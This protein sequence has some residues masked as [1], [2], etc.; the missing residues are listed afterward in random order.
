MGQ[1]IQCNAETIQGV[2]ECAGGRNDG[3]K[4]FGNAPIAGLALGG[5]GEEKELLWRKLVKES[6]HKLEGTSG[7]LERADLLSKARVGN[8]QKG[9]P[10]TDYVSIRMDDARQNFSVK[11]LPNGDVLKLEDYQEDPGPAAT[12]KPGEV[13]KLS[14]EGLSVSA[15]SGAKIEVVKR[16]PDPNSDAFSDRGNVS[17]ISMGDFAGED[18]WYIKPPD[19]D[20]E[21]KASDPMWIIQAPV[22][23]LIYLDFWGGES[24]V[25]LVRSQWLQKWTRTKRIGCTYSGSEPNGIVYKRF[26]EAGE[27][28]IFGNN[29]KEGTQGTFVAFV[30]PAAA[31]TQLN[32][33]IPEANVRFWGAEAKYVMRLWSDD[34]PSMKPVVRYCEAHEVSETVLD[35][36]RAGADCI[37][38]SICRELV[39]VEFDK[40][41]VVEEHD[42]IQRLE[43]A[44]LAK[45]Q[46][47]TGLTWV[48]LGNYR[49]EPAPDPLQRQ[50]DRLQSG[51]ASKVNIIKEMK[52]Q[53]TPASEIERFSEAVG[54]GIDGAVF[55][56]REYYST[57]AARAHL[58]EFSVRRVADIEAF[59][60]KKQD[61]SG[62][63]LEDAGS[64]GNFLKV[65]GCVELI[66]AELRDQSADV[67]AWCPLLQ[68]EPLRITTTK[69]SM[70]MAKQCLSCGDEDG[71]LRY[72]LRAVDYVAKSAQMGGAMAGKVG[73]S[74][75]EHDEVL[76]TNKRM[77]D[78][79][80][81][82]YTAG[83]MHE[84]KFQDSFITSCER[85]LNISEILIGSA[86]ET[87]DMAA[88]VLYL[89]TK[90]DYL[91]YLHI[92]VPSRRNQDHLIQEA[93][94]QALNVAQ[95]L[96]PRHLTTTTTWT[97]M[98]MYEIE[99]R[100]D[101]VEAS[102]V[103]RRALFLEGRRRMVRTPAP[104]ETF[105]WH[106][107]SLNLECFES[108]I[109]L[110][111]V[112][113][114]PESLAAHVAGLKAREK[115][116]PS[117]AIPESLTTT[118]KE[119]PDAPPSTRSEGKAEKPVSGMAGFVTGL[120][121]SGDAAE[122]EVKEVK[123]PDLR[124]Q[125]AAIEK[126]LRHIPLRRLVDENTEDLGLLSDSFQKVHWVR[127]VE[128]A[129]KEEAKPPPANPRASVIQAAVPEIRGMSKDKEATGPAFL[130]ACVVRL[131]GLGAAALANDIANGVKAI[132]V[133]STEPFK[134]GQH[135]RIN[136]GG[137]NKEE[138]VIKNIRGQELQLAEALKE[139]HRA[140][141]MVE[142]IPVHNA[143]ST[144][145]SVEGTPRTP[146]SQTKEPTGNFPEPWIQPLTSCLHHWP[147]AHGDDHKQGKAEKTI[148]VVTPEMMKEVIDVLDTHGVVDKVRLGSEQKLRLFPGD[149]LLL[150]GP[151]DGRKVA[152]LLE[153]RITHTPCVLTFVPCL[154]VAEA[155]LSEVGLYADVH[156]QFQGFR[157]SKNRLLRPT[158]EFK[159][160]IA[161][162]GTLKDIRQRAKKSQVANPRSVRGLSARRNALQAA[163]R[164]CK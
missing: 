39:G 59:H 120:S 153:G 138:H 84:E 144:G 65:D 77:T 38:L 163:Q 55:K 107:I 21:T 41:Q 135:I 149:S 93:Y 7:I 145:G 95:H 98:S 83:I 125:I 5:K 67:S 91:R 105:N 96:P 19:N 161:L 1:Q 118:D 37:C 28:Q 160:M 20:R 137:K 18:M 49:L 51:Q 29:S 72:S 121:G 110:L 154:S 114:T 12:P 89:R 61:D 162:N 10:F 73:L 71:Y 123:D 56:T 6:V 69:E 88:L 8:F 151:L 58:M 124:Y 30:K 43:A 68:W 155:S 2:F 119:A 82:R 34:L 46:V 42:Y 31:P 134:T 36:L 94:M 142:V 64:S 143:A 52:R 104:S 141:E 87:D 40:M 140:D 148:R 86:K 66:V 14:L 57:R 147:S 75:A 157:E 108:R 4:I 17:I 62:A 158:P 139:A 156:E 109:V 9:T 146:R 80:I 53:G 54:E 63:M 100:R 129:P 44:D 79:L 48:S 92:H 116:D 113:F 97:N 131:M 106:L 101:P 13:N 126:W 35:V 16:I 25:D 23:V 132:V 128:V 60:N 33:K 11:V 85:M 32:F 136:S 103:L 130:V 164:G 115:A 22:D 78:R 45:T 90:G 122:E 3:K 70:H 127:Q 159:G 99:V 74:P 117:C 76:A 24:H 111:K 50:F 152:D 133:T 47:V 15:A 150:K 26:F 102:N 27:I 81:E 112:R